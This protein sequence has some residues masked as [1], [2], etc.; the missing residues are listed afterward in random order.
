MIETYIRDIKNFP[1]EGIIF[2][3]ITPLLNNAE[4]R[5]EVLKRFIENLPN[6]KIDKV[7][8]V[9]SRGFFFGILLAQELN[10]G[11]IPVRKKGKLPFETISASYDLEYGTDIL[12]I[13]TDAIQ[14]GENILI[15]DDVLATGGTIKAVT[16]LVEKSGGNIVQLNF[17]M[18]LEFLN[19]KEKIKDYNSYSI[20]KY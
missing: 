15:H 18:E 8:G 20:L 5:K 10:V 13:H 2:K 9:E 14:K 3:D 6:T 7:I 4:A 16:E 17:L 12:E 11:F 1:K 19:G